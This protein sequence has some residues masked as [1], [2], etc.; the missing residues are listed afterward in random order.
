MMSVAMLTTETET[1]HMVVAGIVVVRLAP[2]KA[3]TIAIVPVAITSTLKLIGAVILAY[4]DANETFMWTWGK[5]HENK[6]ATRK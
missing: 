4:T 5:D 1:K 2:P 3:M 6:Y